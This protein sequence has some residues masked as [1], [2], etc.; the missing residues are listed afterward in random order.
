MLEKLIS[1]DVRKGYALP[2]TL[3]T[4]QFL[5]NASLAPLGCQEQASINERG[6][7]IPK[8][9][10]THDQS[11]PGPSGL[12]VNKR[13]EKELLPH[14]MYSFVLS[15]LLHYIVATRKRLP[16]TRIYICKSDIDAA[17]RR[18]HL[19]KDTAPECLTCHNGI[20]LMALRL[21]FGGSPCP[22]LWGLISKTMIDTCNTLIQNTH[23]NHNDLFDPISKLIEEQSHLSESIPFSQARDLMI[24]IPLNDLGFVDIYIDDS[25]GIA[26][27]LKD[28]PQRV[29][30][31]IPLAIKMFARPLDP[32]DPIPRVEIISLKKLQAEGRLEETKTVLGW[33]INTRLLTIYLPK[34]KQ[35][36]WSQDINTIL[37]QHR[38][39]TKQLEQNVG[40]L[41]HTASILPL[42]RHFISRLYHALYRAQKNRWT[43]LRVIEKSDLHLILSFLRHAFNGVSMNNVVFRKPTNIYRSDAIEFGIGGYNILTGTAWR[44]ELPVDCRLRTSLNSLEFIACMISIWLD[45]FFN[46][47]SPEACLLSQTDS[48][49]AAG[50]LR[51]SNFTDDTDSI[52][53]LTTPRHLATLV[54]DSHCCLYSQWFAGAENVVADCLSRDFHLDDI[55]LTNLIYSHAIDQVPFGLQLY[56]LPKEISSWLTCLLRNQP[57]TTQ[58]SKEPTRSKISLGNATENTYSPLASPQIGSSRI[59]PEDRDTVSLAPLQPPSEMVDSVIRKVLSQS[60]KPFG[61]P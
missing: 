52:V 17:Y 41:N 47:I 24:E 19:S 44:F 13:V 34:D 5:P 50:W 45:I 39:N 49:S 54:I 4:L 42:M 31:A 1:E 35:K 51:K 61:P 20:L 27:D 21:T 28:N 48:S 32:N 12:S 10:M 33:E 58:W 60:P 23:W 40:R 56:P 53:Q 37:T 14:C 25:V 38:V 59:S 18:C 57:F 11:Y 8:Y 43:C 2:L 3:N 6:E 15:R 46:Q 9:R 22:S 29:N 55:T 30:R 7:K 36:T 16:S 26:P